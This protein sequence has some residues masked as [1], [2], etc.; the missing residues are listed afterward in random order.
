MFDTSLERLSAEL[1]TVGI[2]S[3]DV[4]SNPSTERILNEFY[5][6]I[7]LLDELKQVEEHCMKLFRVLYKMGGPFKI[8]GDKASH[9][10]CN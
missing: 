1:F 8:A 6:G 2:I 5:I 3:D 9:Y 4:R 10:R 7:A